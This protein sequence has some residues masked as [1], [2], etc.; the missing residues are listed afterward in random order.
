MPSQM[1][2]SLRVFGVSGRLVKVLVDGEVYEQGRHEAIWRGK[3]ESG[4]QMSSGNY[5][6]RLEA[7][8]YSETKRMGLVK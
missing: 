3:D 7:G 6:Y 5:F 2:V 8:P 1:V 4:R